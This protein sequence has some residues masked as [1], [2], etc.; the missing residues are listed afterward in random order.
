MTTIAE[1]IKRSHR[2]QNLLTDLKSGNKTILLDGPISTE[3]DAR[4]VTMSSGKGRRASIDNRE[5]LI[6]VHMD[7]IKAGARIITTHTFGGNRHRLGQDF[8]ELTRGAVECAMEARRRTETEDSVIIAGSIAY[9]TAQGPNNYDPK[10]D[11]ESWES[12]INDLVELLKISRVD[13][14][15]LEMVGGPTFTVP[16]IR[17]VQSSRMPFWVGFSATDTDRTVGR[18][19]RHESDLRV[20]DNPGTPVDDAL[21]DL[22]RFAIEGEKETFK[23]DGDSGVDIIGAMHCK[24]D[25]LGKVLQAIQTHGWNGLMMAY[26][27]DVREWDPSISKVVTGNDPVNVFSDHCLGWRRDFPK[28][29]ILG[30]CCGF[31]VKHIAALNQSIGG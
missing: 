19:G 5:A 24:P 20:Y 17:A 30:A 13:V 8:E 22:I 23:N 12:D 15:L 6:Q 10:Q 28:C 9:H 29:T 25:A 1:P 2:Y 27:D 7:Y 31:S 3:L 11:P 21:P 14:M 18:I 26:P 4:G 16:I